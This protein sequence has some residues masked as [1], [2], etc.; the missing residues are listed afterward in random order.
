MATYSSKGPTAVDHVVKPDLVAP[1][2]ESFPCCPSDPNSPRQYPDNV[3]PRWMFGNAGSATSGYFQISGTSM[4]AAVVSGAV[5]LLLQQNP[6][7][8]P[9]LVK[10]R[11]MKTPSGACRWKWRRRTRFDRSHVSQ[12][13]RPIH[14]GRGLSGHNGCAEGC[15]G[16]SRCSPFS[17]CASQRV[18]GRS[19]D[20]VWLGSDV[21]YCGDVGHGRDVGHS[22]DVGHI[23]ADCDGCHVGYRSDVGNRGHVGYGRDVGYSGPEPQW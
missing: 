8:T 16:P 9:D 10:Y 1:E 7:L 19:L 2:M 15:F 20:G 22:G 21:G 6:Q 14:N 3:V 11:L 12:Q 18:V 13:I 4:S 5:A 23:F 17:D